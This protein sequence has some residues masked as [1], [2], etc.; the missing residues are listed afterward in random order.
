MNYIE[1]GPVVSDKKIFRVHNEL[2]NFGHQR[3]IS[4]K[5]FR[6]WSSGFQ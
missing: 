6:N 1:I 2:N 3:N 5:Q 4:A